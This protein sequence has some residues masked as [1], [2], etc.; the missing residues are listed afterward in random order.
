[1]MK[2]LSKRRKVNEIKC[3]RQTL[4]E[5]LPLGSNLLKI[6]SPDFGKLSFVEV[7]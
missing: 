3:I 5:S 1:M 4:Q 7:K 6:V 2:F